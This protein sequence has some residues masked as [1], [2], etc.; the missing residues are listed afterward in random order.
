MFLYSIFGTLPKGAKG[1]NGAPRPPVRPVG[2]N[3]GCMGVGNRL[4]PCFFAF[5]GSIVPGSD[6]IPTSRDDSMRRGKGA[7]LVV[8]TVVTLL[9]A[10]EPVVAQSAPEPA[11]AA[12]VI[13][14]GEA[15]RVDVGPVVDG[16][17]DDEAWTRAQPLT[18]FVQHEPVAGAP[19]SEHTEVRIIF[20]DDA[21]YV[22]AWLY[23]QDPERI[24]IGERR[25]NANLSQSDAFLV[26]LDTYRDRQNAFVFGTTPGGIEY[27]GQVRGGG[28]INT[29]WDGSWSVATSRDSQGW[30][31]E[32]R[33][34]FSTLRY[35]TSE[36]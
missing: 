13:A 12:S 27:D 23:D 25:R 30:Y 34:P 1:W 28:G 31:V 20:D 11:T 36:Q 19:I 9:M 18:G 21:L 4:L 29:N 35:G 26:V 33:I 15:V 16:R 5:E 10:V 14:N 22:G 2:A 6:K 3:N 7:A 8:S 32:M 17:L 24:I